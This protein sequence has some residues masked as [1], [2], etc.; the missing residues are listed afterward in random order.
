M[1][2]YFVVQPFVRSRK[3]G[4]VAGD[5]FEVPSQRQA[6]TTAFRLAGTKAAAVAF[7]RTGDPATGEWDDAVLIASF[8]EVPDEAMEAIAN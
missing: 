3:G 1:V 6:E 8:G 5:A 7:S 4:L 2:T